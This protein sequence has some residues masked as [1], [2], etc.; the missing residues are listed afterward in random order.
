MATLSLIISAIAI[1]VSLL[2]PLISLWIGEEIRKKNYQREREDKLLEKLVASRDALYSTDFLSALNSIDFVFF[3]NDKI[4]ELVKNLH[5]AYANKE[6]ITVSNQR[7]VELIY[8]ICKYRKY[9]VT[10]YEIQNL[11]TSTSNTPIK[12]QDSPPQNSSVTSGQDN[13]GGDLGP[14]SKTASSIT[15]DYLSTQ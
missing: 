3:R 13:G 6:N 10:E 1:I 15:A 14:I 5:R 7:I 2:S 11:F 12:V 8:E 4:K 9:N